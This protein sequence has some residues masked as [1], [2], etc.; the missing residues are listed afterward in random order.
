VD[1]K[2]LFE[3]IHIYSALDSLSELQKSY[4]ADRK[5]RRLYDRYEQQVT[6]THHHCITGPIRPYSSNAS[7]AGVPPNSDPR[8]LWFLHCRVS[9]TGNDWLISVFAGCRGTMG[10][11]CCR[12]NHGYRKLSA[13]RNGGRK[14][15]K[16][17]RKPFNVYND[18]G[19]RCEIMMLKLSH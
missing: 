7:A 4:Q 18:T 11:G 14:L 9:C 16:G 12:P 1:F 17:Q 13:Y 19:G 5:V 8:N 3:C 6:G 10:R 2:P 15:F